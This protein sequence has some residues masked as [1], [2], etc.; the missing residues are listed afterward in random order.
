MPPK[1][2]TSE[3]ENVDERERPTRTMIALVV[4][5]VLVAAVAV[6]TVLVPELTD[7]G[8]E[9]DGPRTEQVAPPGTPSAPASA[10]AP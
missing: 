4:G 8:D 10:P 9:E 6:W 3:P 7:D 1:K 5:F 2:P